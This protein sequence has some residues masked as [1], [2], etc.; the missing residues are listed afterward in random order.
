M[1]PLFLLLR[2]FIFTISLIELVYGLLATFPVFANIG[3]CVV[4]M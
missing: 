3:Y 4:I 1:N 2:E